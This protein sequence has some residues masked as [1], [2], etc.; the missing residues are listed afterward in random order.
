MARISLNNAIDVMPMLSDI[1]AEEVSKVDYI[2]SKFIVRG[3]DATIKD[4]VYHFSFDETDQANFTQ[5][6]IRANTAAQTGHMEDYRASWRGHIPESNETVTLTLNMAEF[7]ALAMAGGTWKGKVLEKGWAIKD[8]LSKCTTEADVTALNDMYKIDETY[9][10][11][12]DNQPFVFDIT[13]TNPPATPDA[14]E[15]STPGVPEGVAPEGTKPPKIKLAIPEVSGAV[16]SR[17]PLDMTFDF[18]GVEDKTRT[19]IQYH[20]HMWA[21]NCVLHGFGEHKPYG[22]Y[23]PEDPSHGE[24][25]GIEGNLNAIAKAIEDL[26]VEVTQDYGIIDISLYPVAGAGLETTMFFIRNDDLPA[27]KDFEERVKKYN[28][29]IPEMP[30]EVAEER[31]KAAER[32]AQAVAQAKSEGLEEG[33]SEFRDR[34]D[35]IITEIVQ[36]LPDYDPNKA[37]KPYADEDGIPY[38]YWDMMFAFEPNN[39]LR[40]DIELFEKYKVLI[41]ERY[42]VYQSGATVLPS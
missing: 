5:E 7:T 18:E 38:N 39:M 25:Y 22:Q 15:G 33:T 37:N 34:V 36:S 40:K 23:K 19:K 31:R 11:A 29:A 8:A 21:R 28:A 41:K 30:P 20:L 14:P 3:F 12:R 27:R 24:G 9:L 32:Y 17:H 1:I 10:L 35:A 26:E 6:L 42:E 2:V 4:K 13:A 16:G